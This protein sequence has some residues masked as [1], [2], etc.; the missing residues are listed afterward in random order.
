MTDAAT[1]APVAPQHMLALDRANEVRMA[2]AAL[3]R[4]VAF[5]Q[6]EVAEVILC[7][8]WE[9][10]S[11]TVAELLMCQPRWGAIRCRKVLAILPLSEKK[12]VG[13]MT[14]RQRH[15]LATILKHS[16]AAPIR[17]TRTA[18]NSPVRS[19]I[20]PAGPPTSP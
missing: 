19:R 10:Q 4:R 8:P 16:W 6:I 20:G 9:A 11:M 17:L 5:G 14:P 1:I 15:Q 3:K 7:S 2:R 18:R 12:S 13:S